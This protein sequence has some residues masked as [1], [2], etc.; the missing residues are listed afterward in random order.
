MRTSF[1]YIFCCLAKELPISVQHSSIQ[2]CRIESC[3]LEK[4]E[5]RSEQKTNLFRN[6]ASI[7]P[8]SSSHSEPVRFA[9]LPLCNYHVPYY[10]S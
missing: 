8:A 4:L 2:E 6:P 1:N 3:A 10:L 5:I 7:V 9:L